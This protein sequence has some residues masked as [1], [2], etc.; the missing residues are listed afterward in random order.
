MFGAGII[1][2]LIC[3]RYCKHENQMHFEYLKKQQINNPEKYSLFNALIG[4]L[5]WSFR[6]SRFYHWQRHAYHT[7]KT[8]GF[9]ILW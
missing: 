3:K 1:S 5:N 2:C 4:R 9:S 6:L 8:K 7:L